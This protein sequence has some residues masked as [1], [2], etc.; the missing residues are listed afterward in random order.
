[1]P[2]SRTHTYTHTLSLSHTHTHTRT[3]LAGRQASF[4]PVSVGTPLK[5][6]EG[7]GASGP[8]VLTANKCGCSSGWADVD[9]ERVGENERERV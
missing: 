2:R 7:D 9:G 1:M 6:H 3:A 5:G 4:P 8:V